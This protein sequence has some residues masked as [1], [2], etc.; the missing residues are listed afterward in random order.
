M[1]KCVA[2]D[3][4]GVLVDAVS[5]WRTLHDHFG[6][7]SDEAFAAFLRGEIDDQEFMRIDI[8]LWKAVSPRIHRDEI[9]RAFAGVKLM[10][11]ARAVVEALKERGIYV[12]I[13]SAGVDVFVSSIAA[14]LGA[15]D[16]IANGFEFDDDGWLGDEGI[17]RVSGSRKDLVIAKLLEQNG[18]TANEVISVGDSDIDLSMRIDGNKFIVFNPSRQRSVD[19]FTSAG[20][21]IINDKDLRAIWSEL[22]RGEEFPE[23][24]M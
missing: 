12:A 6:T 2:F 14:M 21:P 11:G 20:V 15:D 24:E 13:V 8:K 19:M 4:D 7:N 22:F 16:W 3:C 17:A 9:F 23:G 18:F 1:L 5:S 10:S